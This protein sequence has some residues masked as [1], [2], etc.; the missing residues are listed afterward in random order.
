MAKLKRVS[1][2]STVYIFDEL[3]ECLTNVFVIEKK[4]RVYIIDTFC[5]AE[6][7]KPIL[8][9]LGNKEIVVINTHFHWDHVLGNC[10]F[11]GCKIISHKKCR[12]LLDKCW[13]DQLNQN[14]E[15]VLGATVKKLPNMTFDSKIYFEDDSLELFY[16]PGHTIDSISI[17][18]REE[19]ILYV[20][21]N[22]EKP[23]I[24]LESSCTE[25]YIKTLEKY[26][27]YKPKKIMGGHTLNLTKGDILNTIEYLKGLM[28]G[29][30]FS[31][32]TEYENKV[33]SENIKYVLH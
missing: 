25:E 27:E 28:N 24:Y 20:G 23:I 7:M 11:N 26:I 17:Y 13:D 29:K 14:K 10:S 16:S 2:S 1:K 30:N 21:D 5:G 4:N 6:Y 9:T 12:S 18:D 22:V 15:Y 33:H 19:E 3:Q 32:K 31:F 8:K